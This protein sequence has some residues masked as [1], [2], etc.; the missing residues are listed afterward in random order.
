MLYFVATK[1]L[2]PFLILVVLITLLQLWTWRDWVISRRRVF[3]LTMLVLLLYA[4]CTSAVSYL[5][6][7]SLEWRHPPLAT[8]PPEAKA[9]VVLSGGITPPDKVR[10][11]AQ[12]NSNSIR[13]CLRGAELYHEGPPCKVLLSGGVVESDRPGPSLAEAMRDLMLQLGVPAEDILLETRSRSTYENA[14]FSAPILGER[15]LD[16][17]LLVTDATHLERS[18]RCFEAQGVQV[19]PAGCGYSAT[20]FQWTAFNFL[21][22][23]SAARG[24]QAV[25]HEWLGMA[26]Y[27][28]KGRF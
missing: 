10:L 5:A 3:W 14:L 2:Q 20:E 19:I 11:R 15:D 17:V 25:F 28:I 22:T 27:W 7:G 4:F 9:I 12:L 26:W 18:I 1:L 13:R 23:P 6:A 21:P 16:P 24:N 8:R